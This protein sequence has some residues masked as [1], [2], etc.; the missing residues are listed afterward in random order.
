M[1]N[2]TTLGPEKFYLRNITKDQ[3]KDT[4]MAMVL[5]S[6]LLCFFKHDLRFANL[7]IILLLIDMI[8]P[9]LYRPAAKLWLGLSHLLGTVVS[10]LLLSAIFFILVT[11]VGLVRKMIGADTLQLKK[12][13]KDKTS[14]FNIR[15]HT[16]QAE[17][18]ERP[19]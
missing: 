2:S 16:F 5:I 8:Y 13:K 18:I 19:Y 3:A 1:E 14:V 9:P 4:G 7:A 11:P 15:D 17:D 6:L 12:W 10:K